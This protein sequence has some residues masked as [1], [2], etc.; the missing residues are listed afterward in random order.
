[1]LQSSEVNS[2]AEKKH[3]EQVDGFSQVCQITRQANNLKWLSET[4]MTRR[5]NVA[6]FVNSKAKLASAFC[7]TIGVVVLDSVSVVFHSTRPPPPPPPQEGKV[8][9]NLDKQRD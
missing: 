3:N 9:E 8:G 5:E 2:S 4:P 6:S 7:D 1:M